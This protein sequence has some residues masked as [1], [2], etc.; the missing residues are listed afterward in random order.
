MAAF[1]AFAEEAVTFAAD[2]LRDVSPNAGATR[3]FC[4]KCGSPLAGRYAYLPG[5]VYIP[6]GLIDQ[7]AEL[8]PSLHAHAQE[9]LPWLHLEDELDRLD[10]TSRE[11][12]KAR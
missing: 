2:E 3:S 9:R 10:G 8:P 4:G 5:Q 7:A 6:I 12:L 11:R 1:A